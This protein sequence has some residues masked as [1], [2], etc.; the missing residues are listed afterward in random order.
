MQIWIIPIFRAQL[1]TKLDYTSAIFLT[2]IFHSFG[3]EC[4]EITRMSVMEFLFILCLNVV[5]SFESNYRFFM[6]SPSTTHP[7]FSC[8]IRTC[9]RVRPPIFFIIR[10][11][12]RIAKNALSLSIAYEIKHLFYFPDLEKRSKWSYFQEKRPISKEIDLFSGRFHPTFSYL[13]IVCVKRFPNV[14]FAF[15]F[16]CVWNFLILSFI[17]LFFILFF[18]MFHA[19][20]LVL[21]NSTYADNLCFL[22]SFLWF[23]YLSAFHLSVKTIV[24]LIFKFLT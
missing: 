11:D 10:T 2:K 13:I 20:K 14:S 9:P 3:M 6:I 17:H 21:V 1:W 15:L 23:C 22:I 24:F 8:V 7:H 18:T 19:S 16:L 4:C 5:N 12:E